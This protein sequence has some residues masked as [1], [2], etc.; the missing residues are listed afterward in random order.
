MD[1]EAWCAAVH[2]VTKSW[3]RLSNFT[4]LGSNPDSVL[5]YVWCALVPCPLRSLHGP[6]T[7]HLDNPPVT[8]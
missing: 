4:E 5:E 6:H 2:G 3:T 7:E 8:G 1:R